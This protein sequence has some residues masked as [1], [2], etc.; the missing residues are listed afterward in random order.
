LHVKGV[1]QGLFEVASNPIIEQNYAQLF[2]GPNIDTNTWQSN[3]DTIQNIV[4]QN[5]YIGGFPYGQ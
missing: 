2:D 1:I 3:L 4:S 5:Q